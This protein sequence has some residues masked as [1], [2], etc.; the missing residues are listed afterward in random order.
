MT[1]ARTL[2]GIAISDSEGY[3]PITAAHAESLTLKLDVPII[4]C[5]LG[6]LR[7]ILHPGVRGTDPAPG[8]SC[9][10]SEAPK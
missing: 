3:Q 2:S 9:T 10:P 8:V 1:D 5:V 4:T 6:A 7:V